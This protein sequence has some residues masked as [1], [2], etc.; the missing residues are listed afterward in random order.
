[1]ND[2]SVEQEP[3]A[4]PPDPKFAAASESAGSKLSSS[5][6]RTSRSH[7]HSTGSDNSDT[8]SSPSPTKMPAAFGKFEKRASESVID[9]PKEKEGKHKKRLSLFKKKQPSTSSSSYMAATDDFQRSPILPYKNKERGKENKAVI[10]ELDE[11]MT[12]SWHSNTAPMPSAVP[13]PSMHAPPTSVAPPAAAAAATTTTTPSGATPPIARSL[14]RPKSSP[15]LTQKWM[16]GS[17]GDMTAKS[18]GMEG[19]GDA[20]LRRDKPNLL[21]L[22]PDAAAGGAK[23]KRRP[24]P[25]PPPYAKTYGARGLNSLVQRQSSGENGG[26]ES[27]DD[28]QSK[29]LPLPDH[30]PPTVPSRGM[31]VNTTSLVS[32]M[33]TPA[34]PVLRQHTPTAPEIVAVVDRSSSS[35]SSREKEKEDDV[36]SSRPVSS[37]NSMEDLL[38]NLEEFDEFSST[39]SLTN[40]GLKPRKKTKAEREYATI[41]RSELPMKFED[42][43]E[44]EEEEE[45]EEGGER[46]QGEPDHLRPAS[47]PMAITHSPTAFDERPFLTPSPLLTC[48]KYN[49]KEGESPSDDKP[50]PASSPPPPVKPP[51]SKR[52][53]MKKQLLE[54]EQ[55]DQPVEEEDNQLVAHTSSSPQLPRAPPPQQPD[56]TPQTEDLQPAPTPTQPLPPIPPH[57]HAAQSP[58]QGRPVFHRPK[59]PSLPPPPFPTESELPE[60]PAKQKPKPPGEKPKPLSEKPKPLGEKPK[61]PGEKPKPLGEKPKIGGPIAPPRKNRSLKRPPKQ[62]NKRD[63]SEGGV[64][65]KPM[66][67][68]K[69]KHLPQVARTYL[70]GMEKQLQSS[71]APVSRTGSPDDEGRLRTEG[72]TSITNLSSSSSPSPLL[73]GGRK[74]GTLEV[75]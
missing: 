16:G 11:P 8:A 23:V 67:A 68:A 47:V 19:S 61:P 24:P 28:L 71:S 31:G 40:G 26:E 55:N 2:L 34:S 64:P 53:R 13:Q 17:T 4:R 66:A 60:S 27:T 6:N 62:G 46:G 25:P 38:K 9:V 43:E 54:E 50:L 39:Q 29:T 18:K 5:N 30:S 42:S 12:A 48:S 51:R 10:R 14:F 72:S 1:M 69:P 22:P 35:S 7:H 56:P 15:R 33:V 59:P 49:T 44:E 52:L 75:W 20:P 70:Q 45:E 57:Q 36:D 63:A 32:M 58:K 73:A 21:P 74:R 65:P 41:P 37:S 3:P